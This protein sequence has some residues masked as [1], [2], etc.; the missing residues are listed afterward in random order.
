M[1]IL[2]NR[3]AVG[4]AYYD[5]SEGVTREKPIDDL[6]L[7]YNYQLSF[8]HDSLI[9]SLWSNQFLSLESGIKNRIRWTKFVLAIT[10]QEQHLIVAPIISKHSLYEMPLPNILIA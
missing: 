1:I 10:S 7:D 6:F 4:I 8:H 2:E 9:T 3:Q 5:K